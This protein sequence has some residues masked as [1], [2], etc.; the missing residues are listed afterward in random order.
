MATLATQETMSECVF[1][2]G[3]CNTQ[4]TLFSLSYAVSSRQRQQYAPS[5]LPSTLCTMIQNNE[6][7]ST[8]YSKPYREDGCTMRKWPA[9]HGQELQPNPKY[10]VTAKAYLPAIFD[11]HNFTQRQHNSMLMAQD[12]IVT[13]LFQ[14]VLCGNKYTLHFD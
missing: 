7:F 8:T 14:I 4:M 12:H 9:K 1:F 2:P 10:L 6:I 11:I 3:M 13:S 5:V